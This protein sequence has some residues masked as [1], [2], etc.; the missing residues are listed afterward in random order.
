MGHHF[1]SPTA[2]EDPR[3]DPTDFFV[4][5][6]SKGDST[7]FVLNVNPDAGRNANPEFRHEA[8]YEIKIDTSCGTEEDRSLRFVFG[9]PAN[10][11]QSFRVLMATGANAGAQTKTE[12]VAGDLLGSGTTNT[13]LPLGN[14]GSAWAGLAADPF[15]ANFFGHGAFIGALTQ[16]GE[17]R[18]EVFTDPHLHDGQPA[19]S[20]DSRNV[21][22]IVI[23]VPN[24]ILGSGTISAWACVSLY[25][26]LPQRQVSRMAN[27]VIVF[28]FGGGADPEKLTWLQGHPRDDRRVF[29][30]SAIGFVA[31]AAAAAGR[32]A[33]P[34]GYAE[35]VVDALLPDVLRYRLGS[36]AS[37]GFAGR[38]GR[39]LSDDAVDLQL[40]TITNT[41]VSEGLKPAGRL[42]NE[43]P[44]VGEPYDVE[45]RQTLYDAT[46]P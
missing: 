13:V 16:R 19:N 25:G 3:I 1:D 30:D 5:P 31:K 6:S 33:D 12:T 21:M 7:V 37:Y 23:D 15:F 39:A 8:I 20:F 18:P 35:H 41:P 11:N 28:Y 34:N 2:I 24:S 38:N 26:H 17:F 29:R 4:F 44:Y 9:E 10:G 22:S 40:S 32:A 46:H 42:R 27:P 43:F 14:G 45:H 36:F